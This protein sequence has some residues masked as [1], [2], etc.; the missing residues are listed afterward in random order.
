MQATG[1]NLAVDFVVAATPAF[2]DFSRTKGAPVRVGLFRHA[3]TPVSYC[4][5]DWV[6]H[7]ALTGDRRENLII[8]AGDFLQ[9]IE[10]DFS[11]PSS[12]K[13]EVGQE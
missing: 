6:S 10:H 13:A 5:I 12:A 1:P 8:F 7:G 4:R 11:S 3:T 9:L 2:G